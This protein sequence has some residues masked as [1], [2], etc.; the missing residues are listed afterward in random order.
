MKL[1]PLETF[2]SVAKAGSFT[3]AA[4]RSG[5]PRST[6]S[7]QIAKLEESLGVRLFKRS[8][9]SMVLTHEGHVLLEKVAGP[10]ELISAAVDQIGGNQAE[11]AGRIRATAPADFPTEGIAE[12]IVRFQ[13][14][15]PRVEVDLTMTNALLDLVEENIDIAIRAG[16]GSSVEVVEQKLAD[17]EWVFAASREWLKKNTLP[18]HSAEISQF[19]APSPSLKA[20]LEHHVLSSASLPTGHIQVDNHMLAAALVRKGAGVA[21]VPRS[22]IASELVEGSV[23]AILDG[24]IRHTSSLMLSFP[25]RA[26]MLPRVRIFGE[27]LKESMR[28]RR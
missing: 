10:I 3:A 5:S 28:S 22:V 13:K 1:D 16:R 21:I 23:V 24:E 18:E 12:A 7:M 9:R 2:V 20:F 11:L 8:T 25:T 14:Q 27:F 15:H 17:I 4:V 26:D 6:V 19:I